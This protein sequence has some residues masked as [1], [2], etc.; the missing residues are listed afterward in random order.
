[1][2]VFDSLKLEDLAFA[3]GE[4]PVLKDIS[5]TMT[6]GKVYA[7]AGESGQGKTTLAPL[8]LGRLRAEK[9]ASY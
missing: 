1:M 2:P 6:A 8:L 9:G 4:K 3:Y 5:M 7:L